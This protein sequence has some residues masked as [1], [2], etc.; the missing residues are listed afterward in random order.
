[1]NEKIKNLSQLKKIVEK[2]KKEN[3]KIIFTNGCFDLLHIG[4]IRYLQEAKKLGDC[5]IVAL[6]SDNSVRKLKGE[7]RPL[8][9]EEER[10]EIISSLSC[11]DYVII[12][13]ELTPENIIL[14]LKPH[15]QVK[16]GDYKIED[17]PERKIVESYGGKV[18]I[19]PEVKGYSTTNLV[20]KILEQY[21]K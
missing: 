2:L 1:M 19:V 20:E 13:E 6:N 12:F 21:S 17:I 16:G 9:P 15:I 14:N 11:V 4:H 3:K 5:L 18:M 7:K 10:A 8:V